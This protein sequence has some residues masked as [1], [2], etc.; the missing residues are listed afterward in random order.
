MDKNEIIVTDPADL[1]K[2]VNKMITIRGEVVN[3]KIPTIIGVDVSSDNPD[4]RGEMAEATGVLVKLVIRAE[5]VDAYSSGRGAGVFYRLR[6]LN[7]PQVDAQ[8]KKIKVSSYVYLDGSAN[9]YL[10]T[11]SSIVYDPITPE[12][13]STGMYSGG[14]PYTVNISEE[15]FD[16]LNSVFQKAIYNKVGQ[17]E[18]RGKGTGALVVQDKTYIFE[19]NSAQKQ[20]IENAIKTITGTR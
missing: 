14:E 5:D 2:Y 10:I 17:T 19:M 1:E 3:S 9:R 18:L 7:V 8:V 6:D 16:Q 11:S 15:Q 4:L 13:S 20:E 12:K